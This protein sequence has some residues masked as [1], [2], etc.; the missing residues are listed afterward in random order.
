MF[1]RTGFFCFLFSF[2]CTRGC[3]ALLIFLC[4]LVVV[5]SRRCLLFIRAEYARQ[6]DINIKRTEIKATFVCRPPKDCE[7]AGKGAPPRFTTAPRA[8]FFTAAPTPTYN[9]PSN[10]KR[11][12]GVG[13]RAEEKEE[14]EKNQCVHTSR[15]LFL[16]ANNSARAFKVS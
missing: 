10:R 15:L 3:F 9:A 11:F 16:H 5:V 8:C 6:R 12:D 2:A 14:E 7:D 13:R 1:F 4:A